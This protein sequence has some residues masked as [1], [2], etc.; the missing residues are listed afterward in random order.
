MTQREILEKFKNDAE[1]QNHLIKEKFFTAQNEI[2]NFKPYPEKWS[3][4]QCVDHLITTN[5]LYYN[6]L[7]GL[8]SKDNLPLSITDAPIKSTFFGRLLIKSVNPDNIKKYK[9]F[10]VLNPSNSN[11]DRII[12][13]KF[14]L[15]QNDFVKLIDKLSNFNLFKIKISSPA[16]N[17]VSLNSAEVFWLINYHNERHLNQA[18][19]TMELYKTIN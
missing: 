19:K 10:G 8:S 6:K 4:A 14:I 11:F 12:F 13:E 1:K 18:S 3:A 9:T 7:N 15:L 2:L 5:N 16:S 17:L